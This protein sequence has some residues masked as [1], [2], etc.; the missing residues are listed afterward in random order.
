M[1]ANAS[2]QS[3]DRVAGKSMQFW[4]VN[5]E[6]SSL[7]YLV[8]GAGWAVD[9]KTSLEVK[10]A[11]AVIFH[12]HDI[13]CTSLTSYFFEGSEQMDTKKYR[14]GKDVSDQSTADSPNRL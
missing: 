1:L 13:L 3:A 6:D 8:V 2:G 4:N 11:E 7:E 5:G 14:L 12:I 10:H 9:L